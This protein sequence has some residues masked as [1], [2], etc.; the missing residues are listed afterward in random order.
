MKHHITSKTDCQFFDGEKCSLLGRRKTNGT[1]IPLDCTI[2]WDC[3][4]A[5]TERQAEEDRRRS[6]LR[7]SRLPERDQKLIADKY[8]KGEKKWLEDL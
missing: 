5:A 7:L 4:F 3:P 8:Y 6:A 2:P 1:V